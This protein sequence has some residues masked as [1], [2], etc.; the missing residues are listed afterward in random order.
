MRWLR[1]AARDRVL[2]LIYGYG[3]G[4]SGLA[5]STGLAWS[6]G[7]LRSP[8]WRPGGRLLDVGSGNGQY[9]SDM[10][11][12]GWDV[13]GVEPSPDACESVRKRL[14]LPVHCGTLE[15]VPWG[16]ESFDV[17]TAWHVLEHSPNP[18]RDLLEIS[19]LLRP[20]GLF[21]GEV[22][23]AAGWGARLFRDR[24]YHW[25]LPRHLVAFTPSTLRRLIEAAGFTTYR[26]LAVPDVQGWAGS[27]QYLRDRAQI[28]VGIRRV[29]W[30]RS[31][32]CALWPVAILAAAAGGPECMRVIAR[33][34]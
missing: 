18:L 23:N 9:M 5:A 14:N 10:H 20:G 32:N 12:L 6:W 22:P 31:A 24:W 25:D 21:M 4:A 27:L 33:Q 13:S 19:R 16:A 7:L 17:V 11:E 29:R 3:A 28:P 26:L 1:R 34:R 15:D 30:R 2:R 8:P